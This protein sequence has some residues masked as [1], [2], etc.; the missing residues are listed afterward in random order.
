MA[1]SV[2]VR[3]NVVG[4]LL[5]AA[6]VAALAQAPPRVR[7]GGDVPRP[8]KIADVAPVYPPEAKAKKIS[9]TVVLE[10]VINTAG[11]VREIQLT[12]SV[13]EL[14]DE[15][16]LRAVRR[17]RYRPTKLDGKEVEV[18]MDVDVPFVLP[19]EDGR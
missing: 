18:I 5:A 12:K 17:W 1:L 19:R 2:I 6:G 13:H 9:G 14:L 7:V 8:V 10:I 16:A 4:V 11:N 15:Q 3:C